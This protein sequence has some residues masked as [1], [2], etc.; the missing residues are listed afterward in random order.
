MVRKLYVFDF[1]DTLVSS[2]ALVVVTHKDGSVEK[3]L[4]HEFATYVPLSGDEFDF[5]EF[6]RYPPNGK[7]INN[8]F[9]KMLSAIKEVGHENVVVLSARGN[10]SVMREFLNDNGLS[11]D[12]EIVGVGTSDPKAKGSYVRQKVLKG[13]YTE[14]YVF[15]DSRANV[16]A[17]E[18]AVKKHPGIEFF[19]TVVATQQESMLRK[20]IRGIIKELFRCP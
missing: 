18:R 13:N 1:D 10:S 12:I 15:D 8:M 9:T 7:I 17:M 6:D 20:T 16:Q 2:G 4:S 3:L 5:S 14:V 19:G 11:H